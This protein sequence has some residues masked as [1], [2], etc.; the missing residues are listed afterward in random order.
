MAFG[1]TGKLPAFD[2]KA[3]G[4]AGGA[5]FLTTRLEAMVG[6]ARK[7]SL[8]PFPFATACCGIEF[9]SVAAAHYDISRFGSEVIRFSPRQADLLIVAGT[10]TDKMAPILRRIYDE[11]PEPKWVISMGVCASSGGFYRAYHV[12]QGIDEIVPVDVYVPGCPPTPEELI[13]AII[14]LQSK[15]AS[16]EKSRD[17]RSAQVRRGAAFVSAVET[18]SLSPAA[19]KIR[20]RVVASPLAGRAT[21]EDR[22]L[23]TITVGPDDWLALARLLRDDPQC[24]YDLF[25]DLA[26]VDNLKRKGQRTRFEAVAHLHSLANNQHIRVRVALPDAEKPSLPSVEGVWP[27]ANWY[28]REAFDLFGFD[29]PGH[30]NLHRLLCHDAFVGHALRKDY[31]PGQRWFYTESDLRVPDWAKHTEERAGSFETQTLSIG[32]SHPATHGIVHLLARLDG[33]RIIRAE[34][35]IG[36][37]HRCFEKMAEK[38]HWNQVIPYADR[39]NYV[40]AMVNGVGYVRTVEK[41]LG[42]EVPERGQ[43]VRTILSEFTRIVDHAVCIGANSSTSAP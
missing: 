43:L 40:S 6:W 20:E 22:D 16:G 42:I 33:E 28:E 37:L 2:P 11:M 3:T 8:W 5:D 12:T 36:Y 10:V 27:A 32:P 35:I 26:G 39:L 41:M 14:Q 19:E 30:P 18:A 4:G 24:R 21:V 38:H 17:S 15:I 9:M 31:A 34:T 29:F 23:P 25:L 1:K 7:N 13:H